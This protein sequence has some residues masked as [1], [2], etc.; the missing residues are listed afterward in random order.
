MGKSSL[1]IEKKWRTGYNSRHTR[2]LRLPKSFPSGTISYSPKP[3]C[4]IAG[5]L[6]IFLISIY[7]RSNMRGGGDGLT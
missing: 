1:R 2:R 4:V 5:N 6:D 7:S 3:L